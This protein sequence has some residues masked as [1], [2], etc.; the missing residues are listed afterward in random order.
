MR[1]IVLF[2]VG[3]LTL[4]A[5]VNYAL[6]PPARTTVAGSYSVAPTVAWNKST[7]HGDERW[8]IDGNTLQELVFVSATDGKQILSSPLGGPTLSDPAIRPSNEKLPVYRKSMTVL[9]IKELVEA[10]ITQLGAVNLAT[11][12][13]RAPK[14]GNT[15]GFRFDLSF[16]R[17]NG[18]REK[19]F[20]VGAQVGEQLH[21]II[22]IAAAT[23]YYERDLPEAE[24]IVQSIAFPKA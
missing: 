18:L 16:A 11:T 7:L 3:S 9:D 4:Y 14:F 24:R 8:T 17:K 20:V 5:C 2:I 6:V 13:F 23:Y 1:K 19:G 22:F 12:N 15:D 10:S 21:L